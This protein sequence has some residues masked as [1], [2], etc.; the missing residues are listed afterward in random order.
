LNA[1]LRLDAA[2]LNVD[3]DARLAELPWKLQAHGIALQ[4]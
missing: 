4:A 1:D 2:V 3:V